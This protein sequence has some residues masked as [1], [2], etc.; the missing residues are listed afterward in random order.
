MFIFHFVIDTSQLRCMYP[1]Q[2]YIKFNEE[3]SNL[4]IV[5]IVADAYLRSNWTLY[6]PKFELFGIL[7]QMTF[8][9]ILF[10]KH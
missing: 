9:Y 2:Q 4:Y 5:I 1:L 3:G 8:Y 6:Q 10:K 7:H